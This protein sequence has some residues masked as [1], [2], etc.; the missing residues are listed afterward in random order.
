MSRFERLACRTSDWFA[1]PVALILI[2]TLCF[3]WIMLGMSVDTLT[4]V[5]SILAL[6]LTQLVLVGQQT[7]ER[8]MQHKLDEL[9]IAVPDADST[10]AGEER[11]P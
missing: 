9:V 2:P 7:G 6:T 5:L 8:A 11:K 4:F 1:S 10:V 3:S